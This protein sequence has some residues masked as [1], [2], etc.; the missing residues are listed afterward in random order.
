MRVPTWMFITGL[1]AAVVG[2]TVCAGVTFVVARTVAVDFA[3]DDIPTPRPLVMPTL[4][5]TAVAVAPEV[6]TNTPEPGV[7]PPTP[8]PTPTLGPSPTPDPLGDIPV[9][10]DP[11]RTTILVMGIDQRSA[12]EEPEDAYRTDTMIL[13]QIDPVRQQIGVLS[14]P[15]DLWVDIPGFQ[16][17]KITTAN[18]LGDLNAVPPLEGP[19]LAMET[20]RRNLGVSVDHYVRINF[21]VFLRVVDVVAPDGVE[22]CVEE[23]ILDE[24]Y[25]DEGYGT[26]VVRFDPG[27]QDLGGERLLQYARTRATEGSDFDRN[28]RQQQVIDAIR[29][30]VLSVGGITNFVTQIPA[31]YNELQANFVTSLSLDD[32]LSLGALV[33]G[34]PRENIIFETIDTRHVN[35][36][37]AADGTDVLIPA[38]QGLSQAVQAAFNPVEPDIP[39]AELRR[40]FEQEDAGIVV[41]NNTD[42]TGLAGQ[43]RDWLNLQGVDVQ[44]V[45]NVTPAEGT[46]TTIRDYTGNTWTARY[47]ASLMGIPWDRIRAGG[48]DSPG[49]DVMIA[50]GPDMPGILGE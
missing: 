27:C 1:L 9:W 10:N 17:G 11:R 45:G 24:D 7:T 32:I 26:I 36:G 30:E 21:E 15:R 46:N 49:A 41:Y 20:V 33:S 31:L 28:R 8:E 50:V 44:G 35:F 19:G 34:F 43:T 12:V 48:G 5:N 29:R 22:I 37:V 38:Q 39:L 25:P 23:P 40:R 47:L 18:Y 16:N 3:G 14:I 42:I 6:A 4:A 13:V 2:T